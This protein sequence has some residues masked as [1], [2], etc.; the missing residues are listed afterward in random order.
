MIGIFGGTFDPVHLG[1]LVL[2]RTAL[3]HLNL[4]RIIF[5]PLG[6]P[7]HRDMPRVSPDSRVKM[8]RSVVADDPHFEV[9]T[10]EID[11]SSPSWTVHT[12]AHFSKA[13]P[14]QTLCLLLGSDAFRSIN[15]WYRWKSL[16]DYCHVV[17]VS[18]AGDTS[19][20]DGEVAAFL[21]SNRV[22]ELADT[23]AGE[24]GGI[25]WLEADIP[26]ISSTAVRESIAAG[27]SL[28]GL[29]APPVEKLIRLNGYYGYQ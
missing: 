8:L 23:Q 13:L 18:R 25:Y 24:R 27:E 28:S 9:S 29:L 12:L 10:V 14:G 5:V 19:D 6:I 11:R 7:P 20:F 2:A 3:Q 21:Q 1:H 22:S 15:H 16:L 17:V 26:D 4:E